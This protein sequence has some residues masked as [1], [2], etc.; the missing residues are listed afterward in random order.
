MKTDTSDSQ[1]SPAYLS[2][3]RGIL[4]NFVTRYENDHL[5]IY[6]IPSD[7][8]KTQQFISEIDINRVLAIYNQ[9]VNAIPLKC[10]LNNAPSVQKSSQC[11]L[12]V[13]G[14]TTA[15]EYAWVFPSELDRSVWIRELVRRRYAYH[16]V[17]YPDFI[18]LTQINLQEGINSEKQ[19]V[20]A[21]V[22]PGR[23]ALCTD[24]M[25]DEVDLRKYSSLSEYSRLKE[26]FIYL[27]HWFSD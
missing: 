14:A 10:R 12:I 17:I 6:S 26:I 9:S 11:T 3:K 5:K 22:Y 13:D 23:L 15:N 7:S 25:F 27:S 4:K 19:Q 8:T 18:L 21:L 16:E 1:A 2:T 20:T 24:T